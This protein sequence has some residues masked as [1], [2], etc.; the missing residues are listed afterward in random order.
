MTLCECGCGYAAP[1]AKSSCASRGQVRGRALRFIHGH[2]AR[3]ITGRANA[4]SLPKQRTGRDNPAWRGLAVSYKGLHRWVER[5][6][7]KVGVCQEC[8]AE[9]Y[10]E[11]ANLSGEYRRDVADFVELCKPCHFVHDAELKGHL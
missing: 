6:K 7:P 8:G 3:T 9:G 10:T 4:A 5:H 2:Y 11:N 1:I